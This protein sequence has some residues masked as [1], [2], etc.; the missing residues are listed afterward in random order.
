MANPILWGRVTFFLSVCLSALSIAAQEKHEKKE[1]YTVGPHAVLTVTNECGP[2]TMRPSPTGKV[3]VTMVWHS[4]SVAFVNEQRGDRLDLRATSHSASVNIAEYTVLVPATDMVA[5]R[6]PTG[7]LFVQ[8]LNGDVA[9]ETMTSAITV[10][11]LTDAHIKARTL[12]GTISLKGVHQTHVDIYSVKGDIY[13]HDV[14]SSWLEAHSSTGKITYDG[15][16]GF[17]GE[18][19]LFSHFGDLEVSIPSIAA[20]EIKAHSFKS[21][22]DVDLP[23]ITHQNSFLKF[24]NRNTSRFK[25]RSLRGDI[26]VSRP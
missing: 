1:T 15:D 22:Q 26:R 12:S 3:L 24:G 4:A 8:G 17:E 25:L 7:D 9:L 21:D 5:V 20:V 6:S 2:I 10:S 11:D 14:G 16:P 23:A 13:L 19:K 18:Y